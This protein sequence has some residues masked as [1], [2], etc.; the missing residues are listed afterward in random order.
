M[1]RGKG[2]FRFESSSIHLECLES[3]ISMKMAKH[4]HIERPRENLPSYLV[5]KKLRNN[6][7]NLLYGFL[8]YIVSSTEGKF[9]TR[10]I[11]FLKLLVFIQNQKKSSENL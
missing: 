4:S 10:I 2:R 3:W 9:Q 6:R 7:S 1:V 8:C 11:F 5:P